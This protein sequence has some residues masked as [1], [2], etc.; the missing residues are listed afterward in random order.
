MSFDEA[1]DTHLEWTYGP[2][3]LWLFDTATPRGAEALRVS[4]ATGRVEDTVP[5]PR[6]FRPLLA[7]DADGLWLALAPSGGAPGRGPAPLYHVAPGARSAVL[8]HRGGRAALWLAAAGHT[9]WADVVSGRRRQTI[10]RFDGPAGTARRLARADDLHA[11]AAVVEPGGRALWAASDVPVGGRFFH[12][13]REQV[14]R[15]DAR[16]GRRAV[17]AD[18]RLPEAACGAV[19]GATFAYGAFYFATPS[20]LY[21]IRS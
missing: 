9:V 11:A 4:T 21:R 5:L 18:V 17:V 10:W 13:S 12:C 8:V 1:S 14:V 6:I 3:S 15:I 7:A 19:T 20:R 2:G 16:T